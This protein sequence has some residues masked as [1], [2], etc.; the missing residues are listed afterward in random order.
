MTND[1]YY[2]FIFF[3]LILRNVNF[4][5]ISWG[6]AINIVMQINYVLV[7]LQNNEINEKWLMKYF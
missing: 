6:L 1:Q 5:F 3:Y 4:L 2:L 7:T